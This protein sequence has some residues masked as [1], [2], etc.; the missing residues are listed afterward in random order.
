MFLVATAMT[1][2][3][4]DIDELADLLSQDPSA[5]MGSGSCRGY[6][7]SYND[8]L[9]LER[10]LEIDE[11]DDMMHMLDPQGGRGGRGGRGGYYDDI[12]QEPGKCCTMKQDP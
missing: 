9:L 12:F 1:F 4:D 5:L 6:G 10:P 2:D 7:W 8:I 3:V 11:I